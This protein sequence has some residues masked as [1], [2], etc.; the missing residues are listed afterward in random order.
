MNSRPCLTLS[1]PSGGT[2]RLASRGWAGDS[3]DGE[4]LW[5]AEPHELNALLI[6]CDDLGT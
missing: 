2:W 4:T 3:A 1:G 6:P 5:V